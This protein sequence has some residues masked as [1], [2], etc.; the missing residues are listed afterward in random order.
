MAWAVANRAS[1]GRREGS[2]WVKY[3]RDREAFKGT[4]LERGL[5]R[6]RFTRTPKREATVRS[7][8]AANDLPTLK[9]DAAT[10]RAGVIDQSSSRTL[11]LA[12]G[13]EGELV[14]VDGLVAG[15]A[16]AGPASRDGL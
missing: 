3:G 7:R 2:Y 15:A 10:R 13:E 1:Q 11:L 16:A 9:A 14:E 4:A 6:L 8:S 12:A 5:R